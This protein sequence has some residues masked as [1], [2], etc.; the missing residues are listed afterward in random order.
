MARHFGIPARDVHQEAHGD[1]PHLD[2]GPLE[3]LDH[4]ADRG[5]HRMFVVAGVVA[6][7]AMAVILIVWLVGL[8]IARPAHAGDPTGYWANLIAQGKAPPA[9]WWNGLASSK[10]PCCS[11]ADGREVRDVDWD[12]DGPN[13]GYRVR[14]CP[15]WVEGGGD[16]PV[17]KEWIAVP[18]TAVIPDPNRY[19]PAVVWPYWDV[20]SVTQIRCFLPGA[21]A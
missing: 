13:G 1:W 5:I 11:G 19:G 8:F 21:G 18:D 15:R 6:A 9:E 4:D 14:L 20:E 2:L 16:C 17:R 10:G 7:L 12:T 3:Q